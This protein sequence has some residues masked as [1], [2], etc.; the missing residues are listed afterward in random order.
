MSAKELRALPSAER[1]AIL[2]SAAQAAD[3]E[4]RTNSELTAF[5]AFGRDDLYG[6][7]ANTRPRTD[8]AG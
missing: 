4:Y 1:D 8:L 6:E 7:S 3:D 2:V 5:E